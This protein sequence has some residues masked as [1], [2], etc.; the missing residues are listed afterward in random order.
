MYAYRELHDELDAVNKL[1]NGIHVRTLY[2]KERGKLS[3]KDLQALCQIA[4]EIKSRVELLE[5]AVA[6]D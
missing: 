4:E 3:E 6:S 5:Q 1:L 2:A